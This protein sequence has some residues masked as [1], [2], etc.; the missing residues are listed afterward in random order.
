MFK[1][2]V[3]T[4]IVFIFLLVLSEIPGASYSWPVK[5]FDEQHPIFS[6]LAEYGA[7]PA[8]FHAGVDIGEGAGV[9]VYPVV[10]GTVEKVET[11]GDNAYVKIRASSGEKYD[12]IHIVPA[13]MQNSTVTAGVTIIGTIRN[14]TNPHLHF[15]EADGAYN[16]LRDGGLTPY[17][18]K[19]SPIIVSADFWKQGTTLPEQLTGSLYGRMDIRVNTYDART[20]ATGE[21][22]GGHCGIYKIIIEFWQGGVRIG[23][24]IEY[25][26][27]DK[28]PARPVSLVY[29]PE[30]T[31]SLFYYWATNDPFNE[32]RDK[33]WNS[34]QKTGSDYTVNA[35]IPMQALYPEGNMLIR[36]IAKDIAGNAATYDIGQQ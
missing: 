36:V 18:D 4:F 14:I 33:Y 23:D 21:G 13:V 20:S 22:A 31:Q 27:Y 1:K 7:N 26:T 3:N 35:L 25:H 15:E 10:S 2:I 24:R 17:V 29:A 30:T 34:N 16:P 11:T 32:P 6:T 12:Y 8:H 9:N 19:S 28:I 5:P